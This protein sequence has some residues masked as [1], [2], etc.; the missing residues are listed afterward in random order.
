M[1]TYPNLPTEQ[2]YQQFL[3]HVPPFNKIMTQ[4]GIRLLLKELKDFHLQLQVIHIAGTNGKGSSAKMLESIAHQADISTG[5][6]VSPYISDYRECIYLNKQMISIDEMNACSQQVEQAYQRL[7]QKGLPLPTHYEC[8]TVIAFLAFYRMNVDLCIIETLMGGLNDATNVFPHKICS[9]I[10]SISFDHTEY[11]GNTLELIAYQKAGILV[12]N[13]FVFVNN[14]PKEVLQVLQ[15]VA[16]T[17]HNT[18]ILTDQYFDEPID[19]YVDACILKGHHQTAN[20][21]GILS[22][23]KWLNQSQSHFHFEKQ[24]ILQGLNMIQHPCRMEQLSYQGTSTLLDGCHNV[25]GILALCN[26][27]RVTYPN[28][29]KTFV[30]GCLKDKDLDH[31]LPYLVD[32]GDYFYLCEPKN[33][34]AT[35]ATELLTYFPNFLAP[36]AEV[37]PDPLAAFQKAVQKK[38]TDDEIIIVCGSLYLSCYIRQH[39]FPDQWSSSD[40]H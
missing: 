23:C 13:N 22:I 27:L 19:D 11:L 31:I 2:P 36:I 15:K 29:K 12:E 33:E 39:Y 1:N 6:F 5:C 10:T 26:F 37:I 24:A 28:T 30:F 8:I 16:K 18:L 35:P 9:L 32:I 4:D 38:E 40:L 7:V 20:L 25:D 17:K 34:R 21:L 3:D 14:N